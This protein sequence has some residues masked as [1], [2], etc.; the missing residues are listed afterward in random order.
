MK[1]LRPSANVLTTATLDTPETVALLGMPQSNMLD[2][3]D[4][5]LRTEWRG[6]ITVEVGVNDALRWTDTGARTA[7]VTPGTYNTVPEYL[8]QAAADMNAGGGATDFYAYQT[9]ANHCAVAKVAG[10]FSLDL[11]TDATNSLVLL[12]GWYALDRAAAASHTA[13]VAT[14]HQGDITGNYGGD[15]SRWDLTEALSVDCAAIAYPSL[16]PAGRSYLHF[17]TSDSDN[18]AEETWADHDDRLMVTFFSTPR[19]YQFITFHAVD[20][21]RA[22]VSRIGVGGLF[23]GRALD[24][25][26]WDWSTYVVEGSPR[27]ERKSGE[28]RGQP[29]LSEMRPGETFGGSFFVTSRDKEA[30]ESE[31]RQVGQHE[32]LYVA[33]DPDNEPNQETWPC[34]LAGAPVFQHVGVETGLG[35]W[36]MALKFRVVEV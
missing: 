17:G 8:H 23:V 15:F 18:S 3:A 35:W 7:V 2:F 29:F 33:M 13:D 14:I 31:F 5:R 4:L 12:G 26:Q 32:V 22:D 21:R 36:T 6:Q 11:E 10:T 30:L 24:L 9:T 19:I 34:Y 16:G 20:P 25:G 1:I 27:F 28:I